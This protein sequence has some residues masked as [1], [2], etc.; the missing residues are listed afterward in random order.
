[1]K[2]WY[3]KKCKLSHD[4]LL[5]E[6][7]TSPQDY[8][9]FLRM[10]HD[11]FTHLLTAVTPLIEKKDTQFRD[12]IPPKERLTST[13]RFLATGDSFEDLKFSTCISPQSLGYIV[14]ETCDAIVSALKDFIKEFFALR[15]CCCHGC[16][17]PTE[18]A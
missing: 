14:M 7:I 8:K 15:R 17:Y 6:V 11:T 3:K 9:N 5:N 16:R 18:N 4:S 13:L 2:E 12:A 1:M 10:D